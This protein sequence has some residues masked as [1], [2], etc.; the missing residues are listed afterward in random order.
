MEEQDQSNQHVPQV[1]K[2][3]DRKK[4]VLI[5]ILIAL[6][7][8][9]AT[10]AIMYYSM[11]KKQVDTPKTDTT[12][13]EQTKD[14]D[15]T[16]TKQPPEDPN[17]G[18][19]VIEEWGVRLKAPAELTDVR[20]QVKDDY[21][22]FYGKPTG[23]KVNYRSDYN[24]AEDGAKY[25]MDYLRRSDQESIQHALFHSVSGKKVGDKY[26]FTGY[27]FSNL[28]TSRAFLNI[29]FDA[30]CDQKEADRDYGD[31][32]CQEFHDAETAA[33]NLISG[34]KFD[35]DGNEINKEGMLHTIELAK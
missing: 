10:S 7:A 29:F 17:K 5:I 22:F 31:P 18:Y 32:K 14:K 19:L 9:A 30:D 15:K 26:Y 3:P 34:Y 20:Y 13:E 6:L 27:S 1:T 8:S 2:Q 28:E 23:A 11:N 4:T 35:N 12:T 33:V 25:A 21:V 16:S 24:T